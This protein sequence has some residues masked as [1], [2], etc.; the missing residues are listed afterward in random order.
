MKEQRHMAQIVRD[1]GESLLSVVNDILDLSRGKA[2]N[3]PFRTP[4]PIGMPC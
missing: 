3:S 2:P 1:S 4:P